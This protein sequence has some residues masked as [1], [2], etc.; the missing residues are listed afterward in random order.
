MNLPVGNFTFYNAHDNCPHK[1]Y[2]IYVAKDLPKE[3]A[4]EQMA[5]GNRVHEGMDSRV[6]KRAPLP[7]DLAPLEPLA[8][9]IEASAPVGSRI[10]TE[11]KLGITA[12]GKA[13]DFF[14]GNVW[15]RG[16][17]DVAIVAQESA[18]IVDW[19]TGKP[20][21]EP[22]ELE[23]HA[24]MLVARFPEIRQVTG[25]YAWTAE[26][27]I[28]KPHHVD[29]QT[30]GETWEDTHRRRQQMEESLRTGFWPKRQNGLCGWCP[31]SDCEF[32]RRG[33]R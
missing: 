30:L 32:Y 20:R 7:A 22:W 6:G 25:F 19:K 11:M 15:F 3:P 4:T 21:E 1:A 18:A 33:S 24:L 27:R 9:A 8:L 2:R 17:A 5:W 29:R 12:E 31:V 26:H 28:G 13:C 23:L 16:K 10:T 14:A